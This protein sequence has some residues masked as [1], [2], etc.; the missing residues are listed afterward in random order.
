MTILGEKIVIKMKA[1]IY[2][3]LW[4]RH[5]LKH[6]PC[7]NYS[8]LTTTMWSWSYY[9]LCFIDGEMEALRSELS[10][11]RLHSLKMT[12]PGYEHRQ[13]GYRICVIKLNIYIIKRLLPNWWKVIWT[14]SKS[15]WRG[16]TKDKIFE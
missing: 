12:E 2:C 9:R 6:L 16:T 3:L 14:L 5:S 10:W 4:T 11:P 8:I 1:G 7:N 15:I 13:S